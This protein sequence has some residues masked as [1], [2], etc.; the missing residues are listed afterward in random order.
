[1]MSMINI[2]IQILLKGHQKCCQAERVLLDRGVLLGH[3]V[4][5]EKKIGTVLQ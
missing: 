3:A 4:S 5:E 2:Q 1:M